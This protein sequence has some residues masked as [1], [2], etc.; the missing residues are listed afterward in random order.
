V[1][2]VLAVALLVASLAACGGK[3]TTSEDD[4]VDALAAT[5]LESRT[6]DYSVSSAASE[7]GVIVT[8][9]DDY[10]YASEL[11]IDGSTAYREV[12][13]DDALAA[14]LL[15]DDAV[16]LLG[17]SPEAENTL[18]VGDWVVDDLGAP[19]TFVARAPGE[20]PIVDTL[21]YFS[22]V[23]DA[24]RASDVRKFDEDALDYRPDE[25]PFPHPED[26]EIRY[27]VLPTSL[28]S[29][30]D[31]ERAIGADVPELSD[32]RKLAVYVRDDHVVA[33]REAID[34]EP[35]VDGLRRAFAAG[36]ASPTE[37]LSLVNDMRAEVGQDPL[38][39]RHTTL[40]VRDLGESLRVDLPRGTAARLALHVGEV[41][42]APSA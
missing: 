33:I 36:D 15:D 32:L 9:E 39:A 27:D 8:V 26:G 41:I 5:R 37:L 19:A 23:R 1:R 29:R 4:L 34:V 35:F 2:R 20:D 30:A 13:F 42:V 38:E 31:I 25:D 17:Q 40:L 7:I 21:S 3:G 24:A 6:L 11:F 28:P 22:Y 12:V 14:K 10:R 16:S 18:A